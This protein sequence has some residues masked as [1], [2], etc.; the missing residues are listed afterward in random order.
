MNVVIFSQLWHTFLYCSS[1]A[2]KAAQL[3]S[4]NTRLQAG[5]TA[6]HLLTRHL[7][8]AGPAQLQLAAANTSTSGAL[9]IAANGGDGLV[10]SSVHTAVL[11][12]ESLLSSFITSWA[13]IK[14]FEELEAEANE[15]VY[16]ASKTVNNCIQTEE[17]GQDY[18]MLPERMQRHIC[19]VDY[20]DAPYR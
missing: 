12:C 10:G 8:A 4:F 9:T 19:R 1:Q 5:R 7:I 16:K 11:R 14:A 18:H 15:S 17:V 6:L 2:T 13:R 20:I 3:A